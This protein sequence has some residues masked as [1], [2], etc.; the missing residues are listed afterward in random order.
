MKWF[1]FITF[2]LST[3]ILLDIV[4]VMYFGPIVMWNPHRLAILLAVCIAGYFP[5]FLDSWN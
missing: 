2:L 5:M 3:C 1:S 4:G